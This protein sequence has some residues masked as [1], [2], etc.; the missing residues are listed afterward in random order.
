METTSR[1]FKQMLF[2]V[3][4]LRG[5]MIRTPFGQTPPKNRRSPRW[6]PYFKLS[7]NNDF[8]IVQEQ[9]NSQKFDFLLLSSH[10]C[11]EAIDGTHV[12]SRVPRSHAAKYKDRKH[13]TSQNVLAA[14]DFDL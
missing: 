5:E 8:H 11:I 13:Y 6:Y 2:A 3:G 10:D 4:E 12:T 14:I 1:Y 9:H 7:T